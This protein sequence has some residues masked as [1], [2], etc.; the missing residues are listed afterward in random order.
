MI[1]L[2][3]NGFY[4]DRHTVFLSYRKDQKV[5]I[6]SVN[7]LSSQNNIV[8]I[9]ENHYTF[10]VYLYS[11]LVSVSRET[12]AG[13]V[14]LVTHHTPPSQPNNDNVKHFISNNINT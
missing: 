4:L 1:Q 11:G 8:I 9:N 2:Y 10:D 13:S 14:D 7:D 5:L 3:L 6:L 12:I